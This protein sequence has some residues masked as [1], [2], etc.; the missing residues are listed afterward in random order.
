MMVGVFATMPMRDEFRQSNTNTHTYST[1]YG[2]RE[3]WGVTSFSEARWFANM[4][5]GVWHWQLASQHRGRP[6]AGRARNVDTE[7]IVW[8][9]HLSSC[10]RRQGVCV[11]V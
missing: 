11:C 6:H 9:P 5:S 8:A 3:S 10:R 1:C 4:L 7:D 2:G